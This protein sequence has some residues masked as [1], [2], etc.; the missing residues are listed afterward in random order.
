MPSDAAFAAF[1]TTYTPPQSFSG[2]ENTVRE[3]HQEPINTSDTSELGTLSSEFGEKL[4]LGGGELLPGV[5][6]PPALMRRARSA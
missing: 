1:S 5:R 6:L 4:V 2:K 3:T